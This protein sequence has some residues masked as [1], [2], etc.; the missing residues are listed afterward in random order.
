[1]Q[2]TI[3]KA[4]ARHLSRGAAIAMVG[5]LAAGCSSDAVRFTDSFYTASVPSRTSAASVDQPYPGDVDTTATGSVGRGAANL[6]PG[7][8][9]APSAGVGMAAA[10][11]AQPAPPPVSYPA[12]P[13]AAYRVN[14]Y[15]GN[16]SPAAFPPAPA[17][18]RQA[19]TAPSVE[20][21]TLAAPAASRV[22]TMATGS[23]SARKVEPA[24]AS[25]NAAAGTAPASRPAPERG[26]GRGWTASGG[27]QITLREGETVYNLS[28]RFGVPAREIMR[29]NGIADPRDVTA[30]QRIV[31]PTYVYSQKAPTSAP[32]ANPQT[33]AAKSSRGTKYDVPANRVPVPQDAP[34]REV[35]VVREAPRPPAPRADA[36]TTGTPSRAEPGQAKATQAGNVHT[37]VAGDSL[38]A[39]AR[40]NGVTVAALKA[41]NNLRDGTIRVGQKLVMPSAGQPVRT[42]SAK[43]A[44]DPIIT[45]GAGP[46]VK[47]GSDLP[48]YTPPQR[49][50]EKV[51]R[52]AEK[53]AAVAPA[54]TGIGKLRWP[55][56]GRIVSSFGANSGGK[57]NDGID[58][59]VPAGTPVK[60][61]ENG[62]VIYAGSGLKEFGNTVLIRHDDGLVSVYGHNSSLT[63]SRGDKVRRGQEIAKAGNSGSA[64]RPKLHFE[65]R[66][67]SNPVNPV[68]FLE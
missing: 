8:R 31:I 48:T 25:R 62:V 39:I 58:I 14:P 23:T 17:P 24:A 67:N 51:I 56:R 9:V 29:V 46:S 2:V 7:G 15:P 20:R 32:D 64:N 11:M 16:A 3:F 68:D 30:G 63:V 53:V 44:V 19:V 43:P 1:M 26:D 61:A 52:Q 35:A 36:V 66:K 21:Q 49:K 45:G 13:Q 28:R 10:G 27:T 41:A 5:G 34:R 6:I 55:V 60:A 65:I 33:A 50:D 47:S 38:Y 37:V 18:V 59:A 42:A 40:R 57:A 4:Y 12:R 54:T 22:D